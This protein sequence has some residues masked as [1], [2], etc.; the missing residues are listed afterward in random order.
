M[1]AG[2]K[3]LGEMTAKNSGFKNAQEMG[4]SEHF[5]SSSCFP[6]FYL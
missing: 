5:N 2:V 4:I 1:I 6:S 3:W